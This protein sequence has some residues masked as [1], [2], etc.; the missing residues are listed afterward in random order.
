MLD[1]LHALLKEQVQDLY[2]A[3]NQLLKA[4]PK[5]AKKAT[6]DKLKAA[7]QA[8]L[9]ETQLHVERLVQV[10][11]I[12][13]AKPGGK[14]CKAMQGLVEEGSEVLKETGTPSVI[15]AALISAAQRVEHYE[16]AAYTGAYAMAEQLGENQ[17]AKLFQ[18]TLDEELVAS[19]KLSDMLE[20]DILPATEKEQLDDG[21][22]DV[23]R[24]AASR[25]SSRAG[26]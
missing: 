14:V 18:K 7:F 10:A 20:A 15:D 24:P 26:K 3:E 2:N 6:N 12:L 22:S 13:E 21:A 1:T 11:E 5:L 17:A 4:L 9:Q 19:E 25:R 16:I 8:H 23:Q